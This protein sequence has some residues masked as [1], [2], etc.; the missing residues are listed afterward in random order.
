MKTFPADCLSTSNTKYQHSFNLTCVVTLGKFSVHF[1]LHR[2]DTVQWIRSNH[3][4]RNPEAHP[5]D[6]SD[7]QRDYSHQEKIIENFKKSVQRSEVGKDPDDEL[8]KVKMVKCVTKHIC[9]RM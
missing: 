4:T 9:M 8:I 7:R 5:H 3:S 1:F 2:L 6:W